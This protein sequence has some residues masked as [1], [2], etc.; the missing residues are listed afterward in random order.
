MKWKY[1]ISIF[2]FYLFVAVFSSYKWIIFFHIF[3]NEITLFSSTVFNFKR[4]S[5]LQIR[6]GDVGGMDCN[7]EFNATVEN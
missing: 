1:Q 3:W 5:V 6:G 7:P 2:Y 4:D